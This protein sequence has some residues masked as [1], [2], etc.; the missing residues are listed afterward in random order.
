MN[1]AKAEDRL[2][3][4][5]HDVAKVTLTLTNGEVQVYEL[6]G[7]DHLILGIVNVE[8]VEEEGY[9]SS[10][11]GRLEACG[12][13]VR[14]FIKTIEQEMVKDSLPEGLDQ[15][16]ELLARRLAEEE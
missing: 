9:N 14:D 5:E 12:L 1:K 8:S 11:E 2:M 3:N 4:M 16:I 6:S 13:V 15:L 7:C 10:T